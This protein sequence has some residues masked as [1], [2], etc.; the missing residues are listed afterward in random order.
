MN[1][2]ELFAKFCGQLST[3]TTTLKKACL[4]LNTE[5]SEANKK[6][7][8]ML[9]NTVE[10]QEV[11]FEQTE[12]LC[13]KYLRACCCNLKD[14]RL[15]MHRNPSLLLWET[16][17]GDK[18]YT[19]HRNRDQLYLDKKGISFKH[20]RKIKYI[21]SDIL[22]LVKEKTDD[23]PR[24]LSCD[25]NWQVVDS[26]LENLPCYASDRTKF[27]KKQKVISLHSYLISNK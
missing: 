27:Q 19:M 20:F 4:T 11:D 25:Y 24:A 7:F 6:P 22:E 13:E 3:A 12:I 18:K 5:L 17:I 15:R 14:H 2:L 1:S 8:D 23:R 21:A 9:S 26:L 16:I 10:K